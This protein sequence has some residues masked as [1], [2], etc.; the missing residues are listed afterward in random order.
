MIVYADVV[1]FANLISTLAL[2][3]A[4]GSVSGGKPR[5]IRAVAAGTVSGLYAVLEQVLFLPYILR[6]AVL[7]L[8]TAI[9]FGRNSMV[10]N[11]VRF[12]FVAVCVEVLFISVLSLAGRDAY[13]AYGSVTVFCNGVWGMAVYFLTYPM[14]FVIKH[15]V[16]IRTRNRFA[17]FVIN[18]QKISL[19]LLY[20][21]GNLLTH[22]GAGVAVVSWDKIKAFYSDTSFEEFV[23]GA[24]DRMIFGTVGSGGLMPVITPDEAIIDGNTV[25]IKIAVADRKFGAFDGVVGD[26]NMKGMEMKCSS[27]KILQKSLSV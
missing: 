5:L 1:F 14:F 6:T 4:Y 15:C 27:L 13:V 19:S 17:Q 18:G 23:L 21:S 11:T 2:L 26:L 20:D 3:M 9:A 7:F 8:L 16:K 24:E 25:N 10:Y 22:K 12:A